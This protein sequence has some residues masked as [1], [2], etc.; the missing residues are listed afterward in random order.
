M[1]MSRNTVKVSFIFQKHGYSGVVTVTYGGECIWL[2]TTPQVRPT[3]AAALLD[4]A[5]RRADL[6][7][8]NG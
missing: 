3:I 5:A 7:S 8:R 4:A 6:L 2:E 1:S